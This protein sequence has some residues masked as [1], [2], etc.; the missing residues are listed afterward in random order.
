MLK[1]QLL[2]ALRRLSRHK[3]T[4]GINLLG[5]TFGI[6]SCVVIYLYVTYEFSYD[7]FHPDADRIYRLVTSVRAPGLQDENAMM[8]A[9]TGAA[10]RQGTTG[11]S[12]VTTLYTD[13][14]RVLV[15]VAGKPDRVIPGI[16]SDEL[17]HITFADT[18]YLKIFHYQW[19][20]GNPATALQKPF[21]VVLTESEARRY[22]QD[23]TPETWMG[24]F[25]VYEDSLTVSVTGIIKYWDQH[26]DFGFKDLIS[27]STLENSFLKTNIQDMNRAGSMINALC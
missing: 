10:L 16:S 7:R 9:P 1:K 6:L 26:T 17:F 21:S 20:A 12:A 4:T 14:T 24:R 22:F 27:Y 25:V 3:L 15:P 18:D 19:L 8:A 5:L 2:F 23:G 11:F 13:D